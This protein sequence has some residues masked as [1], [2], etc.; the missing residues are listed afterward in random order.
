[1]SQDS[2]TEK[3]I[4]A[5]GA[6]TA[7]RVTPADIEANIVGQYFFTAAQGVDGADIELMRAA[8][9]A[10]QVTLAPMVEDPQVWRTGECGPLHLLTF[11]V[12]VLK[13]GF[14]VTGESACASPENFNAEI[15]RRI[16]RENAVAKIWPLMGYEL[17]SKL[18]GQQAPLF[19]RTADPYTSADLVS[20]ETMPYKD[21]RVFRFKDGT[22]VTVNHAEIK[23]A[24]RNGGPDWALNAALRL[25]N[26][27]TGGKQA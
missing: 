5:A 27:A 10:A 21:A 3:A 14:T 1:M 22:S 12:L 18:A 19:A 4:Q 16:A 25:H 9:Q 15:G 20:W 17:R 11:C 2:A 6:N 13:N 24:D 8:D 23:D 26:A 7:P